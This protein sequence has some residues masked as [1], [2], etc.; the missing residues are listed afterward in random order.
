MDAILD[1]E[2][3]NL[4]EGGG[5]LHGD[6][7]AN[8]ASL[9]GEEGLDGVVQ[10]AE[11]GDGQ[12]AKV[13][14]REIGEELTALLIDNGERSDILVAK[15]AEGVKGADVGGDGLCL[16]LAQFKL[17][18]GLQYHVS[19]VKEDSMGDNTEEPCQ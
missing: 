14:R 7:G 10:E 8:A 1:D 17:R 13:T 4:A 11:L 2:L 6:W 3:D 12:A 19:G 9:G 5:V 15:E 16:L 18:Q